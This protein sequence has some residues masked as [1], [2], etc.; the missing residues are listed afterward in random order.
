[1]V[2]RAAESSRL[3]RTMTSLS[4]ELTLRKWES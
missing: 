3:K 1:M 4:S 2:R